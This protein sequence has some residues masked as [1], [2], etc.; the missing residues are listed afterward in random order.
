[1]EEAERLANLQLSISETVEIPIDD[2]R[3]NAVI[4]AVAQVRCLGF[5]V[6]LAYENIGRG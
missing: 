6:L 5:G 2:K 1:M 3:L 4:A